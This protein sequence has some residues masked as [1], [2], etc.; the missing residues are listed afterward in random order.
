MDPKLVYVKTPTG[1]EAVRQSAHVVERN[2]RM[3]L[4]QVDGKLSIAEM[5]TKIGNVQLVE[6]ALRELEEG[7]FIAPGMDG[8]SVWE[9][10]NRQA[11]AEQLLELSEFST[12]GQKPVSSFETA[13][14][15][16]VTGRFSAFGK[17]IFPGSRNTTSWPVMAKQSAAP[18]IADREGKRLL[19]LF[20]R[21]VFVLVALSGLL[22]CGA[23]F[24]PYSSLIPAFETSVSR[25][26]Q[27]PVRIAHVGVTFSPWPQL[28]LK[29]I[30]L[31]ESADSRIDTIHIASPLSLLNRGPQRISSIEVIGA[32]ISANRIVAL[33]F[34]TLRHDSVK[35][36]LSIREI[37]ISQSQ[38][39][40][41]ELALRDLSGVIRFNSDGSVENTSF[42]AVDRSIQLTT[43][44]TA[45]GI[46]L[47]INGRGWK[48]FGN[49]ISF[50]SLQA[51]GLLQKN[52]LLI[53]NLDT[54]FLGGVLKGTWL[55]DWSNGLVI[56]GDATLTRLDCGQVSA[57]FAPSLKLEGD[58]GGTL[59]LRAGGGDWESMWQ[60]VEATFN[61]EVTRGILTGI[62]LGEAAR[63]GAG[64]VSRAGSTKFDRLHTT[65]TINPRQI[66]GRDVQISAGMMT[67]SGQFV[68]NREQQV[69]G[70]LTVGIQTSASS[71][72]I[73][74]RI[75]GNLPDLTVT[76][77]K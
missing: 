16:S 29:D 49:A 48:P 40:I 26:L 55:F 35:N 66:S 19:P 63:R 17:P 39:T 64:S 61:A 18:E 77:G 34:F 54:T 50:D 62:D 70:N 60:S 24:Y 37:R 3:V 65:L 69:N 5:A 71:L 11:K 25:F 2:L 33:P 46:A 15:T 9:E 32:T 20:R 76:G 44:P 47:N 38:V 68:A 14:S 30:K 27:T 58:L 53:Q 4:L 67:A 59:R 23:F 10:G 12:F 75:S 73:P 56:A 22:L 21:G 1:D 42:E 43:V 41:R 72:Q 28:T 74:V 45:Q 6:N 31:G 51:G 36:D 52:R 8:V 7:G 57:I 13:N